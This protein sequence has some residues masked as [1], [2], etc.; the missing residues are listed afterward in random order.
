MITNRHLISLRT[1]L[2]SDILSPHL[3]SDLEIIY[4]AVEKI[5]ESNKLERKQRK[6][7]R[8]EKEQGEY[9]DEI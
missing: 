8:Y 9:P 3:H 1:V 4:Q 2:D 7:I 6:I 5:V